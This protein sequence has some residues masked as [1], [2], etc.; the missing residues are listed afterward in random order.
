MI[1]SVRSKFLFSVLLLAAIGCSSVEPRSGVRLLVRNPSCR[2][3]VCPSQQILGF[4]SNQPGTPGGMWSLDLGTMTTPTA[5]LMLP[6]S[7]NFYIIDTGNGVTDT[8]GWTI[9]EGLSLGALQ[10][11]QSRLMALP[12][13]SAFVPASAPGWSVD[14]PGGT[15]VSPRGAC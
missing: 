13:T 2:A 3:A 4:P 11:Q 10:P 9:A 8:I 7:A 6:P 5:C 15:Q 1:A 14:L 12:S